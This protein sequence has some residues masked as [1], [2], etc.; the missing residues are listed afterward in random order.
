[1]KIF[2]FKIK[3]LF[4]RNKLL[5]FS[6]KKPI[7]LLT[8][9]ELSK[10]SLPLT[11]LK[12]IFAF[13]KISLRSFE[14]INIEFFTLILLLNSIPDWINSINTELI[15]NNL[16]ILWLSKYILKFR[17]KGLIDNSPV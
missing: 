8:N 12:L 3:L 1:M 11:I 14:L 15:S 13:W 9:V 4:S 7:L 2:V 16:D 5:L 6:S 10:L 17:S